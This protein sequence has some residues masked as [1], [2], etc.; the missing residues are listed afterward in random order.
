M[1]GA[2]VTERSESSMGFLAWVFRSS[3]TS[4]S[5][6]VLPINFSKIFWS[7]SATVLTVTSC[8]GAGAGAG[9]AGAGDDCLPPVADVKLRLVGKPVE[10]KLRPSRPAWEARAVWAWGGRVS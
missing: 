2:K 6:Q 7:S 9:T 5:M 10:V 3:L 8:A 4:A 1:I